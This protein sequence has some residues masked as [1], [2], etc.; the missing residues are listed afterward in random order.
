MPSVRRLLGAVAAAFVVCAAMAAPPVAAQ[1]TAV[2]IQI[3]SQS[4]WVMGYHRGTLDL[5]LSVTNG[6]SAPLRDLSL[7]LSF[8]QHITTQTDY[9]EM[10]SFGVS[11]FIRSVTKMVHPEIEA[12]ANQSIQMRVNL[13]RISA[14]DQS[15]SQVYPSVVELSSGGT[16]VA[17][18][19]TPVI[20]LPLQAPEVP[21]LS[22]TWVQLL[23]PIA[24]GAD[25]TLVDG[26]FP[27]AISELGALQAPLDAIAAN[28]GERHPHGIFDLVVDPLVIT[29]AR[30]LA[31]GYT[32]DGTDVPATDPSAVQADRFLH[33]LDR[34]AGHAETVETVALPYG[35]P[36]LPAMLNSDLGVELARQRDAGA[37]IV[38]SLP[39]AVLTDTI[40]RPEGGRLSDGALNWLTGSGT[41]TVLADAATVD[42]SPYQGEGLAPAPTVTMAS[43]QGSPTMVL[44]DPAVQALFDRT[45]LFS[46]P[47][48]AAQIILGELA[49]IWKQQP[50]P[51][52]PTVR[53]VAIAPPPTLPPELWAPLLRRL[54]D[55]PFL[56]PKTASQFV[57]GINPPNPNGDDATLAAPDDNSRFDSSYVAQIEDASL[58]VEAYGSM[59][60]VDNQIPTELRRRVF[61]ATAPPYLLDPA[62][63][64]PWLG[65]VKA[66]TQRA[67]D[68][69]RPTVSTAFT[70]TS[71]EGT[72]PIQMLGDPGDTPLSV[73]VELDATSFTFPRGNQRDILLVGPG[74]AGTPRPGQ[75]VAGRGDVVEFPVVAEAS[76]TNSIQVLVKAPNG[77]VLD[78]ETIAVRS[79]AVNHI[80]LLVTL[81]A[82]LA[83]VALYSRRWVRRRRSTT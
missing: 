45:D 61:L 80:A 46:D 79:T 30:D 42:R 28:T 52:A 73:I 24:F 32:S 50:A 62:A 83:L 74:Q 2:S 71:R 15:D 9:D 31:D 34:V 4:P 35:D 63:G 10:L 5:Q 11:N 67:F 53:G 25:G 13:K 66:A 69:V 17:S 72:I 58:S 39:D 64:Q 6:G 7:E 36:V 22:S 76:G 57:E 33:Q 16:P 40:A 14:L 51:S 56:T 8:G 82:A 3:T 29:Q 12:G 54:S 43:T 47:V 41:T 1:D 38:A 70:F 59:L 78:S 37:T 44:P 23:A 48:R 27:A 18:V 68:A 21:M 77:R 81:A 20:Y 49:V 19:V 55:A 65:S 26:S 75:I 60:P